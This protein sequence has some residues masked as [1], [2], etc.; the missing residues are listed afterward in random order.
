MF[1]AKAMF[2]VLK[3][4]GM[5]VQELAE[6]LGISRTTLY[7]KVAGESDFT[8][9]EIQKCRDIFGVAACERI[10]FAIEVA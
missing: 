2:E 8:R 7:R 9:K 5:Q 4:Y 6:R 10:F 3:E 1:D